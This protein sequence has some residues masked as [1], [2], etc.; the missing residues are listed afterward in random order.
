MPFSI[1]TKDIGLDLVPSLLL[2]VLGSA[3]GQHEAAVA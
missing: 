2:D 1:S 3:A